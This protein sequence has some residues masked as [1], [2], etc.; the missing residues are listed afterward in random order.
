MKLF[1]LFS[2]TDTCQALQKKVMQEWSDLLVN[3]RE[4]ADMLL[5]WWGDWWMLDMMRQHHDQSLPFFGL[6]CGTEWFLTNR[7]CETCIWQMFDQE[8][9]MVTLRCL[10]V[11]LVDTQWKTLQ[12]CAWNDM[13][14]GGSV[15]DYSHFSLK[16]EDEQL[17]IS[18]T[19]VVVST[20]LWS[21]AYA[22]N[23]WVPVIPLESQVWSIAGIATGEWKYMFVSPHEI[24]IDIQS[25]SPMSV[26]LD[27]YNQVYD[28]ISK[29]VL[30]LGSHTATLAFL[31]SEHFGTR[32]LL[33][34][35]RKLWR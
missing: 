27:G 31:R 8:I 11:E 20:A 3:K 13:V 29:I 22:A 5:I 21:T 7:D 18:G 16:T 33:L 24:Q 19:W 6:N 17:D 34:A 9:D 30:R 23:L 1:P 14:V 15:L 35:E 28:D 26:W 32:R 25:R 4:E 12:W 10:D 2:S